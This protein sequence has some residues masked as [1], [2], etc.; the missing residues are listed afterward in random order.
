M[1]ILW[2]HL[3]DSIRC[4]AFHQHIIRALPQH[5]DTILAS[6]MPNLD[7]ETCYNIFSSAAL[8]PESP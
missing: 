5:I 6:S 7:V 2:I 3:E 4:H 1:S 8:P